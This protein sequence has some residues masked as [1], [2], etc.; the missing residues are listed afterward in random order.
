[1]HIKAFARWAAMLALLA[2]PAVASAQNDKDQPSTTPSQTTPSQNTPSQNTP[3]GANDHAMRNDESAD[4]NKTKT[5]QEK[6]SSA[7]LQIV[8]HVHRV[9]QFEIDLGKLAQ[10]KGT[11]TDIKDF[12]KMLVDDHQAA[13]KNAMALVK[14]HGQKIPKEMTT[15]EEDKNEIKD[16]KLA[17]NRMKKETGAAFDKD[18]L[19]TVVKG[20]E[21]E[22]AKTDSAIGEVQSDDLKTML[23]DI[24]PVL[25]RHA[26]RARELQKNNA[27]A[28][29]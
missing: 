19:D 16:N 6:L 3:S 26:D 22:L 29:R 18:F 7:E 23:K 13:D 1:M 4:L 24:K 9:N 2:T 17:Y 14:D 25:Q 28:S 15:N 8:A 20:H 27:Q 21:K 10:K 11:S 5:G 12:G